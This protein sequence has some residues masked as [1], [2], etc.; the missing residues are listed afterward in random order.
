MRKTTEMAG[1]WLFSKTCT[2]APESYPNTGSE[3]EWEQIELPHTWNAVDGHDGSQYDRGAY[4]YVTEFDTPHQPVTGGKV[5]IEV[6]AASLISEVWVNGKHAG[7]HRGG[8]SAFR[9][10][11]T[12]H[13]V[14][15]G[16]NV[17]AILCDNTYSDKIYPQRADFTFYGGLYRGVRLVS[18][19]ASHFTLDMLGGSGVFVDSTPCEGGAEV[20]V[21]AHLTDVGENQTVGLQIIDA[22]SK[23]VAEAWAFAKE[24]TGLKVFLPDARLW[25]GVD[26]PYL[27]TA[28]LQLVSYNEVV[29]E[30]SESFGIRSFSVDK[31]RGFILNGKPYPL[32]GVCRHQDRLY[33]GNALTREEHFEDAQIIADMGANCVRLA[34]YQQSHDIYEACDRLGLVVWAEIPYFVQSWD[35]DAHKTAVNEIKE[36]VIQNY[37]HPSICFWGLS[38][39]ILMGGNDHPKLIQCHQ[40]LSDAVRSIDTG[41]LTV[42]AHEYGTPWDHKLHDISDVQGWNHYFGWYRGPM[43]ELE[44]WLDE[45]HS[46]YPERLVSVSEYG[47]DGMLPY[48]SEDPAK[49]DYTEEYQALIHEHACEVFAAR[50]WIWGTFVWNMFDFGSSFRREGGTR[51]R[52]NKG[53]VTMDR[54]IKKDAYYVYKA[55]FSKDSFVH[56]AGKRFFDRPGTETEV[57][58]YSNLP[59]VSLYVDGKLH[60]TIKGSRVFVFSNVPLSTKGSFLTAKAGDCTDSAT[61]YSVEEKASYYT[62][63]EFKYAQDARNWFNSIEEISAGLEAVEGYYS[64]HDKVSEIAKSPEA[65]KIVLDCMI[66]VLERSFSEGR[67]FSR[68]SD[69]S[70]TEML[71]V[72]IFKSVSDDKRAL[73][74]NRMNAALREVKKSE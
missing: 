23:V 41:R 56:I 58:V 55:W 65:K 11:V 73:L 46:K 52:N 6:G 67:V 47:C 51:G 64:V 27:Y 71:S 37:N 68:E 17:L 25:Q 60:K 31:E 48:H 33:K 7:S 69:I 24:E 21:R 1:P 72:G 28:K 74:L 66:V 44:E 63:P 39:E 61:L 49:M 9:V 57:R 8:Y 42:I 15:N 18:V 4:W 54:K 29:D 22:D 36:M 13:C 19:A 32:R 14:P 40:D 30:V 2:K 45:Y 53:L 34:H 3:K 50:P 26:D 10:N 35:D 70:L 20:E 16:R 12:E 38:N 5:Y 62:Y 59:E 43:S